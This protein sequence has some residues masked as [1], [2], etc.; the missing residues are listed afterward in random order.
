MYC[1]NKSL[2][3]RIDEWQHKTT[4]HAQQYLYSEINLQLKILD[5]LC[6]LPHQM[7]LKHVKGHQDSDVVDIKDIRGKAD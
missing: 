3:E 2:N 6:L 5:T 7:N 4:I 1:D